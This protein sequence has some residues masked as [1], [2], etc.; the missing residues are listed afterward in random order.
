MTP[1]VD[2]SLPCSHFLCQEDPLV[3]WTFL[4]R[5]FFNVVDIRMQLI[6]AALLSLK[7]NLCLQ[8]LLG[9]AVIHAVRR[10]FVDSCLVAWPH[11]LTNMAFSLQLPLEVLQ[12]CQVSW[13]VFIHQLVCSLFHLADFE[14]MTDTLVVKNFDFV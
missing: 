2:H 8:F 14:N 6:A 9:F 13:D 10:R 7:V 1:L 5:R 12:Y 3:G 11:F 4:R